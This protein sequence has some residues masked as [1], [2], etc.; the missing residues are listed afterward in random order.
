MSKTTRR[1]FLG[2]AAGLA[3]GAGLTLAGCATSGNKPAASAK[4]ARVVVIGGGFGG[5]TAAKYL[6]RF[7]PEL[8]VTL[9][10][11]N[12][13]YYTC[14]GS[15]W[16]LGGLR[17]LES[18]SFTYDGLR[19]HGVKVVHDW[20]TAIDADGQ[21]VRLA[22][23][24][25]LPYDRLVV[26]PGIDF[27]WDTVAGISEKDSNTIPHAWKAGPQTAILRNQIMSMRRGGTFVIVPPPNPFRC[28]PGPYERVSMVAHYL[29]QHNPTAKIIIL[30]P[31]P[32]FSKQGLFT[33]GWKKLY[34]F[35][36]DNSMIEWIGGDDGKV[37]KIDVATRTAYH[38][39]LEE[40]VKADVLNFVPA[41]K[42]GRLAEAAGLTD[43]SGWCPV[44]Q[45]TWEST[46]VPKV[47]VIG[48]AAIQKPL[49]KSGFAANSE[50]K[51]CA[52][53][54]VGLLRG[55][56][57]GPPSFI[58]TC[59]SLVAPHYGISVAMVY[60]LKDGKVAKVKGAGGLT[61][62]NVDV[63]QEAAYAQS[64]WQTITADVWS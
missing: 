39:P 48:D 25:Q 55:E 64:W 12:K 19:K 21:N 54:I 56:D 22:S 57:A 6:K 30:D 59:Y 49:P 58:N 60:T 1:K 53:A 7:G 45:A 32:K 40:A 14:P 50:A 26:S 11:Y 2:Q 5:A 41:Q 35:G 4:K 34:G 47:H 33:A 15:N 46:R 28:P 24:G 52:A 3:A 17:D 43:A 13:K 16:V 51:M 27:R 36:T 42:A 8:E 9:V 23:G 20:V 31:K 63:S 61:P 29:K 10:E 18:I 38:G 37:S 44:N 62:P